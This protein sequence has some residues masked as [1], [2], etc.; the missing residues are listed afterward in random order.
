MTQPSIRDPRGDETSRRLFEDVDLFYDRPAV[1]GRGGGQM[2]AAS[3]HR[4]LSEFRPATGGFGRDGGARVG[5]RMRTTPRLRTFDSRGNRRD[6]VEFHPAYHE[7]DGAQPPTPGVATTRPW[8]GRRQAGPGGCGRRRFVRAAKFYTASQVE[9][10]TFVPITMT[11]ARRWRQLAV[12]AGFCWRK[13]MRPV[14][15]EPA[16]YGSFPS[17]RGWTKARL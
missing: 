15:R 10:G 7:F 11:A 6:E 17:R 4:E 3:A 9:T 14:I 2:A 5:S 1:G 16:P 12:A 8:S 13:A